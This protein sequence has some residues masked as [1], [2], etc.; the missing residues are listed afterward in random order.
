M[1]REAG[2]FGGVLA[3]GAGF[4]VD[5]LPGHGCERGLLHA[6]IVPSAAASNRGTRLA[7]PRVSNIAALT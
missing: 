6:V 1:L 4:T 5:L 2:A 7:G 3:S